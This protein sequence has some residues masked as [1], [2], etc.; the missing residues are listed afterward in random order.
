MVGGGPFPVPPPPAY[1]DNRWF[2]EKVEVIPVHG[3]REEGLV[4]RPALPVVYGRLG[5]AVPCN[6]PHT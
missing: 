4:G 2:S 5:V 6:V 3:P 1:L